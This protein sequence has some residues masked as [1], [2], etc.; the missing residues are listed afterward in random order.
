VLR[1]DEEDSSEIPYEEEILDH[2]RHLID[3]GRFDVVIFEDYNKG[4]LTKK[5][6]DGV[7]A[8]CREK[9]V[10]GVSTKTK[11]QLINILKT[12]PA[13]ALETP[14]DHHTISLTQDIKEKLQLLH[15][16]CKEVA[17]TLKKGRSE[18]VYQNAIC[19]ELQQR[20]IGYVSEETIPILYKGIFVGIE[21]I[22]ICL[23]TW[24]D[25]IFEL[26]AVSAKIS[27]EHLWQV[28]SYL[29]YKKFSYGAVVNFSQSVKGCL[30]LQFVV[31]QQD[32][33]YMYDIQTGEAKKMEDYT[34]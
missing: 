32:T 10:K 25:F 11:Q 13:P 17:I 8:M 6:I 27:P 29:N 28:I 9:G 22:D 21:R 23:T 15:N 18:C 20:A 19:Q 30:E 33:W 1:V 3:S 24:F 12:P 2:V 34:L 14:T 7:I 4:L 26:K 5:V 16:I 31:K